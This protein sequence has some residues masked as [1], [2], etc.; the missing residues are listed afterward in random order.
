MSRSARRSPWQRSVAVVLHDYFPHT[1]D[2]PS[3]RVAMILRDLGAEVHVVELRGAAAPSLDGVVRWTE[4]SRFAALLRVA[5][6]RPQLLFVEGA[7]WGL[8]ATL[9]ARQSWVRVT[10][11]SRGFRRL[12]QRAMIRRARWVWFP[13][14]YEERWWS[15]PDRKLAHL[16]Y[17]VDIEFWST[18]VERDRSFWTGRGLAVPEGPVISYAA[19]LMHG[20]RQVEMLIAL[21]PVLE[22]RPGL[23]LVFA[24]WTAEPIIEEQLRELISANGFAGRVHLLGGVRPREEL[25][26]LYAWSDIHVINTAAET[27]CM[28][29]YESL[30]AGIPNLIPDLPQLTSAFPAVPVHRNDEELQANVRWLLDD[31]SVGEELVVRARSRLPWADVRR[32][33]QGIR[34][35]AGRVL[36]L[37]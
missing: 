17:P 35:L 36:E 34:E 10:G 32:H 26:Q 18:A 15:L 3:G 22:E 24:G 7:S 37:P 16:G 19:Q 11:H 33:D 29:L 1:I 9:G 13:N 12:F 27:Q 20:K 31:S 25:R 6:L 23:V 30:A 8:L 21:L 5:Q 2:Y 14:P 28:V 4:P